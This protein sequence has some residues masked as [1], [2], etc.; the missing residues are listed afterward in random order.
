MQAQSV[1]TG[2]TIP[3]RAAE[4]KTGGDVVVQNGLVGVVANDIDISEEDLGSLIVEGV[5]DFAAESSHVAIAV[6][7][8]LY[9][10]DDGNP[11]GGTAGTGCATTTDT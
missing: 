7:D 2:R 8:D 3:Y 6:G 1:D 5:F 11:Q 10:D 4:D 9:W